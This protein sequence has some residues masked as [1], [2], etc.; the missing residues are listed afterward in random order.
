MTRWRT[1]LQEGTRKSVF[2]RK[3]EC[4]P[5]WDNENKGIAGMTFF[6]PGGGGGGGG[7]TWVFRGV[8]T[9]VIK[10]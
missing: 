3:Y 7:G 9:F 1:Y 10:I 8:H 5:H 4:L 6:A 2:A